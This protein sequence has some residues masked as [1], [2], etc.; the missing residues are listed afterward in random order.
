M[1]LDLGVIDY[2]EALKIQYELVNKRRL[3]EIADSVLIVEHLPVFTIGRGGSRKNL[4][5]T[6]EYL[7]KQGISVI[8]VDRGGDITFHSPGQLVVY[9][10]LDLKKRTKDLHKYLRDLEEVVIS[11][12]RKYTV[13]G[14]RIAGA[15][16]VWGRDK[17]I[18]SI[19]IAAKDWITYHGLSVNI[20]NDTRFFSMINPCGM[21]GLKVTSLK[22]VLGREIHQDP[23]KRILL[24]EFNRIFGI[25][26]VRSIY[27]SCSAMA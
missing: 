25:E 3:D 14:I 26:E 12:L 13:T 15:T 5:V 4:L 24:G 8:D 9:P 6:E 17:K 21:E 10:I 2:S 23:A 20:N 11:F 18:A 22:E 27:E 16:G 19:G 7:G 1:I